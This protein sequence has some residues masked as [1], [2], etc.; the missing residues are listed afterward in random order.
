MFVPMPLGQVYLE[1]MGYLRR[2]GI[3]GREGEKKERGQVE[4]K[5]KANGRGVWRREKSGKKCV[6]QQVHGSNGWEEYLVK[7]QEG[8]AS[9]PHNLRA[10]PHQGASFLI[11][12]P[13]TSLK[14]NLSPWDPSNPASLNTATCRQGH[15]NPHPK[16]RRETEQMQALWI[17]TVTRWTHSIQLQSPFSSPFS[18]SNHVV[19]T[20]KPEPTWTCI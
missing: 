12:S 18:A 15:S 7:G 19:G 8:S 20:I 5:M 17:R 4:K 13:Y 1:N 10:T 9:W 11:L 6:K 14:S 3:K 2:V 16:C